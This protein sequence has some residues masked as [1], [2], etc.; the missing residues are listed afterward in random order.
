MNTL[1]KHYL[2]LED[3]I[4]YKKELETYTKNVQD[5]IDLCGLLSP[6]EKLQIRKYIRSDEFLLL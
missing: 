4:A 3:G 2:N 1:D 5:I 6:E